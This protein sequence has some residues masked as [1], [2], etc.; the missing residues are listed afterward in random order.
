[1]L[2]TLIHEYGD[3]MFKEVVDLLSIHTKMDVKSLLIEFN[4]WRNNL[5]NSHLDWSTPRLSQWS[6]KEV[7]YDGKDEHITN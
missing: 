2:G 5:K 6:S 3:I 1:M 7:T 4:S